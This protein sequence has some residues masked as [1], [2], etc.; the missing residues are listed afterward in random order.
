MFKDRKK[1]KSRRLIGFIREADI[2]RVIKIVFGVIQPCM[3]F[4]ALC[5]ISFVVYLWFTHLRNLN[6]HK[7]TDVYYIMTTL[8]GIWLL[9]NV[10]FNYLS[11]VLV[12]AGTS[13][14]LFPNSD[15][16]TSGLLQIQVNITSDDT[17]TQTQWRRLMKTKNEQIINNYFFNHSN[18]E[19]VPRLRNNPYIWRYCEE[20]DAPKPPRSHHCSIC[21][22][23][24]L[25]MDHHCPW[26]ASC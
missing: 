22:E 6:K 9:F 20:C 23:C 18:L 7:F 14:E 15:T 12:N 1:R 3:V 10:V 25:N 16:K 5:V 2:K 26:V 21:Q 17:D 19:E 4:G 8:M 13:N 24:V 11:A